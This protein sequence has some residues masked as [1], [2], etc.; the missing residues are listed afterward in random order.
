M[1]RLPAQTLSTQNLSFA[2]G[3][4]T[5]L[6]DLSLTIPPGEFLAIVGPNGCGKSTLLRLLIGELTPTRGT[7]QLNG[8]NTANIPRLEI[9]KN[10]ALVPQQSAT[11]GLS[12]GY[13]VRELVLM[14][15]HAANASANPL[16]LGFESP[17]D[18]QLANESMWA[19]DVH[20]LA[21]RPAA[22]LSGGERQRVA[23]ARAL[24]QNN[25]ILLLD[26][27][28]SS[29]DL[30]H[31]LELMEKLRHLSQEESRTIL[32]VTHDLNLAA[33]HSTRT[34]LLDEGRLIADGP[35]AQVLT[36]ALLEPVYRVKVT[37]DPQGALQFARNPA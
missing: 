34:L 4:R 5:V 37:R 13:T 33:T 31:Q 17:E 14:A 12:F 22:A 8:K 23:I 35:P 36:P 6:H 16:S 32:L 11:G 19:A 25:P 29:L 3:P 9:A 10:L 30:F 20:H 2:Y 21:D 27:P 18:L 26:E 7:I 1:T 28:T 15:L 24:T